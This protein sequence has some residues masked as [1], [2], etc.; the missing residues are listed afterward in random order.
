MRAPELLFTLRGASPEAL[1]AQA[2]A[3]AVSPKARPGAK[4]RLADREVADVFGVELAPVDGAPRARPARAR[5]ADGAP[6]K[7]VASRGTGRSKSA[8]GAGVRKTRK[9]RPS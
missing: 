6:R 3:A 8:R 9:P 7:R 1:V 4:R 2:A 5:K